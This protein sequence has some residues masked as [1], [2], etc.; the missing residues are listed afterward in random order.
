M[1]I[2]NHHVKKDGDVFV[3]L[4]KVYYYI[5]RGKPDTFT[6]TYFRFSTDLYF[7]LFLTVFSLLG[8]DRKLP[9]ALNISFKISTPYNCLC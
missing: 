6:S 4:P 2:G 5:L 7:S 8:L 1:Q 9:N 3:P